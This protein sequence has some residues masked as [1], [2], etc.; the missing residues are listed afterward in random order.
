[1]HEGLHRKHCCRGRAAAAKRSLLL[2]D[3]DG[4]DDDDDDDD[5][6]GDDDH[7]DDDGGGY[8]GDNVFCM[9]MGYF[10]GLSTSEGT[11]SSP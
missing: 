8:S 2:T 9:H 3:K 1:M 11:S 10:K 4:L 5:H 7:H 6:R